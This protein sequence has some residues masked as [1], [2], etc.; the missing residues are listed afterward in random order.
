MDLSLAALIALIPITVRLT[1]PI[2]LTAIGATFTERSGIINIGLEGMMLLGAFTGVVGIHVTGQPLM[3]I[4][5]A[6]V[7]G[8]VVGLLFA[9]L[10]ITYQANQVVC[11]VGVNILALGFSSVMVKVIW[12]KEGISGSVTPLPAFTVPGLNKLPVIGSLFQDQSLYFFF[13]VFLVIAAWVLMYRT[14]IG[15]RLRSIGD[16]PQAARTAGV[17]V[18]KYR[19]AFVIFG[20]VLASLGGSYLSLEQTHV[21]VNNM[22]AGRGYMAMAANI[23]G[24]WHPLG[25]VGASI[26][27]AFAQAIRFHLTDF[28][29][30]NQ[31]IQMIPYVITLLAL[32]VFKRRSKAPEALGEL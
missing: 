2:A 24:G 9:V 4:L 21:F 30:P 17:N 19:Y 10:S 20:S 28:N 6:M 1:I 26:I 27:F 32:I 29:V 18:T 23:F 25:S 8:L 16:H 14:K 13:L 3:G 11:G 31:F 15:L 5:F 12:G 22:V 7:S